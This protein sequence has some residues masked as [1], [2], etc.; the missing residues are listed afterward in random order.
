MNKWTP[1]VFI[2]GSS[3]VFLDIISVGKYHVL[4]H[5]TRTSTKVLL[6]PVLS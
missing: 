2:K 4:I 1:S 3:D 5:R 6:A